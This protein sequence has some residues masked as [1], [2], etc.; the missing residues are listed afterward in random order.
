M[1]VKGDLEVTVLQSRCIGAAVCTNEA[2]GSFILNDKKKALVSDLSKNSD[3]VIE[4][5]ARNCPVQAIFIYKQKKQLW[6]E[7]GPAGLTKQ[8]GRD[9]KMSFEEVE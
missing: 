9:I 4:D 8:P 1:A 2:R 5:A 7:S 3:E 6:P